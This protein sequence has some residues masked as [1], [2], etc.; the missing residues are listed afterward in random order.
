MNRHKRS[1]E[2]RKILTFDIL[3]KRYVIDKVSS[4]KIA[5]QYNC[6]KNLILKYLKDFNIPWRNKSESQI[7]KI[8]NLQ[9]RL[10]S[11]ISH[12]G[13]KSHFK[14]KKHSLYSRELISKS[15]IGKF[16]ILARN[17]QGGLTKLGY[18]YYFNNNLKFKI[19]FRDNFICQ[20]CNLNEKSHFRV[21]DIHHIDYNKINCEETNLITLCTK[22]NVQANSNRDYWFAYYTYKIENEILKGV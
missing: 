21:L 14:G 15:L 10:K 2:L 5:K 8:V 16:G 13:Q 22:C 4:H 6:S 18:P 11:S 3:Y 12:M 17:F 1:Q 20:N 19:R 7:G 9:T